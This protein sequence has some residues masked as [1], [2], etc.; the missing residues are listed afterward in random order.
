MLI[1]KRVPNIGQ[2]EHEARHGTFSLNL[3]DVSAGFHLAC[4]CPFGVATRGSTSGVAASCSRR[5]LPAR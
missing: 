3:M 4:C 2:V 5:R 1:R